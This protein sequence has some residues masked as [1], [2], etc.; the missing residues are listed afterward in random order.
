M[1]SATSF[2]LLAGFCMACVHST[3]QSSGPGTQLPAPAQTLEDLLEPSHCQEAKAGYAK[4][5][6]TFVREAGAWISQ[7]GM[8]PGQLRLQVEKCDYAIWSSSN[9]RVV[10]YPKVDPSGR[11]LQDLAIQTSFDTDQALE[12]TV[13]DEACVR[14]AEGVI[15]GLGD[16][17]LSRLLAKSRDAH[18]PRVWAHPFLGPGRWL[19][20]KT[21]PAGEDFLRSVDTMIHESVHELGGDAERFDP[22]EFKRY[23]LDFS[24]TE[25]AHGSSVSLTTRLD[26]LFS[27]QTEASFQDIKKAIA[28]FESMYLRQTDSTEPHRVLPRL[29]D[30]LHAYAVGGRAMIALKDHHPQITRTDVIGFPFMLAALLEYMESLNRDVPEWPAKNLSSEHGRVFLTKLERAC[31]EARPAVERLRSAQGEEK[32]RAVLSVLLKMVGS[33]KAEWLPQD[34]RKL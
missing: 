26:A 31:N 8:D 13:A 20:C 15:A 16:P 7:Q 28:G 2:L 33:H 11:L 23:K 6:D 4:Y 22:F 34:C 18:L 27:K 3:T 9:I 25:F 1:A 5:K 21:A 19:K 29:L 10:V 12:T 17:L 30:E 24:P 32:G 14:A